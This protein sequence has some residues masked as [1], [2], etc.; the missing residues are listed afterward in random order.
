MLGLRQLGSGI[1][2]ANTNNWSH[3]LPE[4]TSISMWLLFPGRTGRV[5]RA[6]MGLY[7]PVIHGTIGRQLVAV[8]HRDSSSP[9]TLL[10]C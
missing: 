7:L 2:M 5:S 1:S 4:E 3:V 8:E 6:K 10:L 9:L